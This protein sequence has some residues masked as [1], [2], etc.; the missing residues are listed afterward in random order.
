M[1]LYIYYT[2]AD[3][4]YGANKLLLFVLIIEKMV[5]RGI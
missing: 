2:N 3:I 1:Y 4:S 5:L